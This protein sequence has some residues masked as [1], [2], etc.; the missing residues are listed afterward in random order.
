MV[1]VMLCREFREGIAS[2][3]ESSNCLPNPMTKEGPNSIPLGGRDATVFRPSGT[4]FLTALRRNAAASAVLLIFVFAQFYRVRNS[5][6]G[7]LVTGLALVAVVLLALGWQWLYLINAQIILEGDTLQYRNRWGSARIFPLAD[8][9][10]LAMRS[11]QQL[12]PSR[13]IS[14][15]IVYGHNHRTL[16]RL[17]RAFWADADLLDLSR[18]IGGR[19]EEVA[20]T[21]SRLDKEFPGSRPFWDRHATW[22]VVVAAVVVVVGIIVFSPPTR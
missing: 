15:V 18:R 6:E 4:A 20:T 5:P 21:A 19:Q 3:T 9:S 10:G 11:L 14:Y 8:V 22:I 16:F 12:G 13:P 1:G 2:R 7:Q 17:V